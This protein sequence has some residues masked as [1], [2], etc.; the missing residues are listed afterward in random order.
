M[1]VNTPIQGTAADLIKRAMINIHGRLKREA[2][3]SKMLL[4]VHD[5]LLFE[6]P[7]EEMHTIP[8]MVKKE[9]EEVYTLAVPLKVDINM[10]RNWGEAH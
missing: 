3:G 6:I 1:A 9:M 10:G 7:K 8:S 2:A 5:E 4:Q